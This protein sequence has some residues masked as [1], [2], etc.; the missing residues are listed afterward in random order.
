MSGKIYFDVPGCTTIPPITALTDDVIIQNNLSLLTSKER[1]AWDKVYAEEQEAN[2]V[3][4][5]DCQGT[6]RT[7]NIKMPGT[8]EYWMIMIDYMARNP[9]SG[10]IEYQIPNAGSSP[11]SRGYAD[12]VDKTTREIFEIK[13]NN[14]DG[15]EAG[16]KEVENYV[17]KANDNCPPAMMADGGGFIPWTKGTNYTK[18]TIPNP[19]NPLENIIAE[20]NSAG[21]IVYGYESR[22]NQPVPIVIPQSVLDKLKNLLTKLKDKVNDYETV[23]A[24]FLRDNP[25]LLTYLQTAAYTAAATIIIGTIVEDFL[26][27]GAGIA[28]DWASFLLARR[29]I[30][31]AAAL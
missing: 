15:I 8:I 9:L 6:N 23:I 26:T 20:L 30:Q 11:G 25:E 1:A 7:G 19:K 22:I 16:K 21:L 24:A 5:K 2:D 28:D 31:F 10:E 29:I 18:R 14:K 17:K 12:I 27:G 13:P 4:N 3:F